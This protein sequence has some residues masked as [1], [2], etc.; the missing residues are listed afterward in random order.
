MKFI[1]IILC[2]LLAA[3]CTTP[4]AQTI[5]KIEQNSVLIK[6][7]NNSLLPHKY[8]I[9]SYEAGKTTNGTTIKFFGPM[10]KSSFRFPVGTRIYVADN[11]GVDIVMGG[12]NLLDSPPFLTVSADMNGKIFEINP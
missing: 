9:V 7:K 8:A 12:G 5:E 1:Q 3:K 11:K 10:S 6:L 4:T 2:L